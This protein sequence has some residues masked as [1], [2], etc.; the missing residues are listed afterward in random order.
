METRIQRYVREVLNERGHPQVYIDEKMER[1]EGIWD[2]DTGLTKVIAAE[3]LALSH[4][5]FLDGQGRAALAE[6]LRVSTRDL[7]GY[8]DCFRNL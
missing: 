1:F 6:K 3:A 4:A 7:E 8:W 2:G 5:K